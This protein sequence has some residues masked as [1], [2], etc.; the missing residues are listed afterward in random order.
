M[1]P[2]I[3]G[4]YLQVIKGGAMIPKLPEHEQ[5]IAALETTV[6]DLQKSQSGPGDEPSPLPFTHAAAVKGNVRWR[7]DVQETIQA[8]AATIEHLKA[9]VSR[10]ERELDALR[11]MIYNGGA[12]ASASS[13]KMDP[14]N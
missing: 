6:A 11:L 9:T 4:R 2:A 3:M 8:Q 1:D 5:R 7:M 12:S 14:T 13:N 10:L